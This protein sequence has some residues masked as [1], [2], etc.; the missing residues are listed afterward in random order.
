MTVVRHFRP[1]RITLSQETII[2]AWR[3]HDFWS[4]LSPDDRA[5]VPA[6]P[7]GSI[8]AMDTDLEHVVIGMATVSFLT[9]HTGSVCCD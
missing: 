7:A 5:R 1:R 2:K 4:S 3:D 8:E 6:N 9:C